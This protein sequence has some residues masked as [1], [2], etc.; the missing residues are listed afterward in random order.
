[1]SV[2]SLSGFV[3]SDMAI[4]PP[5]L[6]PNISR[7]LAQKRG[8]AQEKTQG[9]GG[10]RARSEPSGQDY[11]T[12]ISAPANTRPGPPKGEG[13]NMGSI[14]RVLLLSAGCILAAGLGANLAGS[15]PASAQTAAEPVS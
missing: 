8:Y 6:V 9:M 7:P 15:G 14:K 5:G 3:T 12:I 10:P 13:G 11:E 1:M 2:S 4:L